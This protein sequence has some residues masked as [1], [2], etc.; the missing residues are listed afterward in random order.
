ML[1]KFV[2]SVLCLFLLT[3]CGSSTASEAA[4]TN[5]A[6][7]QTAKIVSD[8]NLK[9]TMDEVQPRIITGLFF[10][11]EGTVSDSSVYIANNKTADVVG[12]F[13]TDQIDKT[14]EAVTTYL[15]T[16]KA[17]MESYYPDEVFKIDNAIVDDNG[18]EVVLIVCNDLEAAK[19]EAAAIL[20]K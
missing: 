20:G 5:A 11:E 15:Q 2:S 3:A 4:E 13:V 19:K 7:E 16:Q 8:L 10:F 1:R 18:S 17:Q 12:V 9:D 6:A 14:K